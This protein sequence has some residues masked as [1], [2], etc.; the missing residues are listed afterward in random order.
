MTQDEKTNQS[1]NKESNDFELPPQVT[2]YSD[3][4]ANVCDGC[5]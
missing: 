4:N 5:A 3:P 2:V 1:K